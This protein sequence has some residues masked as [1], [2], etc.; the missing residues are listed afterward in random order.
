MA[1]NW[2]Y[3]NPMKTSIGVSGVSKTAEDDAVPARNLRGGGKAEPGFLVDG[4]LGRL[5]RALRLLGFDAG[6]VRCRA[7]GSAAEI[8][9]RWAGRVLLTRDTRRCRG[10][11][12]GTCVFIEDDRWEDQVQQVLRDLELTVSGDN[13]FTRCL[14]CNEVLEDA[15]LETVRNRVPDHVAEVHG[16]FRRCPACRRVYWP[17]THRTRM[18]VWLEQCLRVSA[19]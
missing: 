6:Y 12:A 13:C 19:R 1:V 18:A 8:Q 3:K 15:A 10:A 9:R 4:M 16:R 7:G 11:A 14:L 17:G 5:A 2:K